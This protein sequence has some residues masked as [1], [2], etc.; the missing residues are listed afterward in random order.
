MPFLEFDGTARELP[1]GETVVGSGSQAAWRVQDA[2]LAARHFTITLDPTSGA[3]MLSPVSSQSVVVVNGRQLGTAGVA[4][5]DGDRVSAGAAHFVSVERPGRTPSPTPAEGEAT[6]G[7]LVDDGER[8]AYPVRRRTTSIG[9]DAASH[10]VVRD[11]TVSRFHADV[12]AEAGQHVLY[13]MGSAGT[14]INGV[15]V[16]GPQL[17]E[18]GDKIALGGALFRYTRESVPSSIRV[19]L[20]GGELDTVASV[21]PTLVMQE[22]ITAETPIVVA[23][24]RPPTAVLLAVVLVLIVLAV[25]LVT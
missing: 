2:G 11:P 7:F 4:L 5:R 13:S 12:R 10:I 23:R 25:L 6:Q 1:R 21:R 20:G 9:R 8:V 19:E 3:A 16:S 18:E 22:A 14:T 15:R 24:R 17:L